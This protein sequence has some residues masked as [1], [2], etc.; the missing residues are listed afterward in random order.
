[1]NEFDSQHGRK[2]LSLSPDPDWPRGPEA[3]YPV[4]TSRYL[5]PREKRSEHEADYS[6]PFSA[7]GK[8]AWSYT[9][10][11]WPEL[12]LVCNQYSSCRHVFFIFSAHLQP[13]AQI[14]LLCLPVCP[15]VLPHVTTHS[16]SP[17]RRPTAIAVLENILCLLWESCGTYKH[18]LWAEYRVSVC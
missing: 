7:E 10:T 9:S 17:S 13:V 11:K 3:S 16:A 8:N 5:F 4:G 12:I 18:N 14:L 15:S 1:M 2:S 6:P